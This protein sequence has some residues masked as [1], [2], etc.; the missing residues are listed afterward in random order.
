MVEFSRNPEFVKVYDVVKSKHISL[1]WCTIYS[2]QD[3]TTQKI[4]TKKRYHSKD[5]Q[6]IRE[7]HSRLTAKHQ[8]SIPHHSVQGKR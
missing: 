2:F 1:I 8:L 5:N 6:D 4:E 3:V 7:V